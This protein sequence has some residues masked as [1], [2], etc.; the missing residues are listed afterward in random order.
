MTK[1]EAVTEAIKQSNHAM[2][3]CLALAGSSLS[4]ENLD[5]VSTGHQGTIGKQIVD[6]FLDLTAMITIAQNEG[7]L[8]TFALALADNDINEKIQKWNDAFDKS[9]DGHVPRSVPT[10][11]ARGENS[12]LDIIKE[13]SIFGMITPRSLNTIIYDYIYSLYWDDDADLPDCVLRSLCEN[14]TLM[15]LVI[16]KVFTSDDETKINSK[17]MELLNWQG[18]TAYPTKSN[19]LGDTK[20]LINVSKLDKQD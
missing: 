8:P 19:S 16:P 14:D 6:E 5:N 10:R 1:S 3:H 12:L 4:V 18:L 9:I 7:L 13:E 17:F 20:T 15:E 2:L 11:Y